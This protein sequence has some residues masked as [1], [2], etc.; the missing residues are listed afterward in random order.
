MVQW[1][2]GPALLQLQLW[3]R[4]QLRL[5]F[6]PSR[7]FPYALSLAKK[8]KKKSNLKHYVIIPLLKEHRKSQ[9]LIIV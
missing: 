6:N 3:Q 4:W 1:V 7:E 2:K 9:Q 5:R 8:E